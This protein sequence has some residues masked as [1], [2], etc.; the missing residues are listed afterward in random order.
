ML[1]FEG[2][3]GEYAHYSDKGCQDHLHRMRADSAMAKIFVVNT[4]YGPSV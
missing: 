3:G 4:Y 2:G 1:Q